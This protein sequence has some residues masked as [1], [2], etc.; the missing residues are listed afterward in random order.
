MSENKEGIILLFVIIL[1][2]LEVQRKVLRRMFLELKG[3][4]IKGSPGPGSL[5][6]STRK[7]IQK[8]ERSRPCWRWW[9]WSEGDKSVKKMKRMEEGNNKEQVR[10]KE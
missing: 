3:N 2:V 7:G 10:W 9:W 5:E 4:Y 6:L 1:E 8:K